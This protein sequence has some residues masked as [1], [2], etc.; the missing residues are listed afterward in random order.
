MGLGD[1]VENPVES[2]GAFNYDVG[3]ISSRSMV[4]RTT[5]GLSLVLVGTKHTS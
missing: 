3:T 4:R 1:T 5:Y 2:N